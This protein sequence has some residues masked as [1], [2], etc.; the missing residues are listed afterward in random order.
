MSANQLIMLK[1]LRLVLI[2][3]TVSFFIFTIYVTPFICKSV[4][5]PVP[6]FIKG[7]SVWLDLG[8]AAPGLIRLLIVFAPFALVCYALAYLTNQVN[9]S[10]HLNKTIKYK[11]QKALFLSPLKVTAILAFIFIC[12]F[13]MIHLINRAAL[14]HYETFNLDVGS[15][16]VKTMQ[17]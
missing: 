16:S 3:T 17:E 5:Y 14:N 10:L 1:I 12:F 6:H 13:V 8:K 9:T 11:Y 4:G 15:T 7:I 2:I